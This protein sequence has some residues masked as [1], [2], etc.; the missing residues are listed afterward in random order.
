MLLKILNT[1]N[2]FLCI[3]LSLFSGIILGL[4]QPLYFNENFNNI[5]NAGVYSAY[6]CLIAYVYP[7]LVM[8][9]SSLIK[10]LSSIFITSFTGFCVSLYWIFIAVY[11]YGDVK[12]FSSVLITACLPLILSIKTTIFFAIASLFAKSRKINFFIIA[13]IALCGMEF[14]RNYNLFGGFPWANVGYSLARVDEFLQLA[15]IVGIYGIVLFVGIINALFASFLEKRQ[16]K[17]LYST[18]VLLLLVF[19]F[20]YYR[21]SNILPI[22]ESIKIAM[23]QGN[24][25]QYRKNKRDSLS[26]IDDIYKDLTLKASSNSVDLLIWPESSYPY[27][28]EE[29]TF[30]FELAKKYELAMIF[31]LTTFGYDEKDSL[32]YHYQNSAFFTDSL[33]KIIHRYDKSHLVP[34]GEYV[35][36]PMQSIVDKIVPGIGEFKRGQNMSIVKITT[37]SNKKVKLGLN[38]CY[39]GI[40]PEQSK[41][42]AL[43]EPDLLVNITNDA[44][45]GVSSA[46]YQHLLMYKVRST[47]TAKTY[48]RSTNSGISAIIDP[49]GRIL[50]SSK[51]FTRELIIADLPIYKPM[52]TIYLYIGD[53]FAYICLFIIAIMALLLAFPVEKYIAYKKWVHLFIA[54]VFTSLFLISWIYFTYSKY[55]LEESFNTKILFGFV[56]LLCLLYSISKNA[57]IEL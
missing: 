7:F 47:E 13:P 6:L 29:S 55:V 44:W 2:I 35:P 57:K 19:S 17:F 50:K 54:F 16:F 38:I 33:G 53:L 27:S 23:A 34:F 1:N 22:K 32:G 18:L 10:G 43:Q 42:L 30:E 4:S 48:L 56:A 28:L 9:K 46:P 14:F 31:G 20:G 12:L 51:L 40:F 15:S 24:V 3:I 49:L 41:L 11:F 39:E 36:W 25:D 8:K 52:K 5:N 21:L 45:Y 26:D 37:K